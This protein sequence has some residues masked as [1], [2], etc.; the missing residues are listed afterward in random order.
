[1]RAIS[2]GL[3]ALVCTV[4]VL[5]STANSASAEPRGHRD[6]KRGEQGGWR[7]AIAAMTIVDTMGH[8]STT[9]RTTM[10]RTTILRT[11]TTTLLLPI[12]RRASVSRSG[13]KL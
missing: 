4:L 1:M 10:T 5:A 2:L 11:P 12:T 9:A 3:S 6:W 7:D 8:P 13:S